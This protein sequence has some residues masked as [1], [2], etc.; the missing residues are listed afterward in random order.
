MSANY[1]QNFSFTDS[2]RWRRLHIY[3]D[4]RKHEA[5]DDHLNKQ[6]SLWTLN[7]E[8]FQNFFRPKKFISIILNFVW[9]NKTLFVRWSKRLFDENWRSLKIWIKFA[10]EDLRNW[11][12]LKWEDLLWQSWQS[13]RFRHRRTWVRIQSSGDNIMKQFMRRV[14]TLL[15]NK[16]LRLDVGSQALSFNQSEESS[17]SQS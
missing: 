3:F 12:T 6:Q 17:F 15:W 2:R 9:R 8:K 10:E 7:C 4:W 13:G 14:S 1:F 11:V 5:Q 16:A